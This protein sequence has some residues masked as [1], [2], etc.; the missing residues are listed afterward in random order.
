V[1]RKYFITVLLTLMQSNIFSQVPSVSSGSIVRYEN[2]KSK[3]ITPRN[4]DVWLPQDYDTA[5]KYAVLYMQDGQM[6]FDSAIT[7]DGQEW[8]VDETMTRLMDENK[9]K[10]CIV[11]GIWNSGATRDADYIPQ[12]PIALLDD[13]T[14]K[15]ILKDVLQ[16]P[17]ADNYLLFITKELKPFID[18]TYSTLKDQ[19]NTFIAGSSKGGL[20]SLYAICEYPYVFGGA[21]CISIHWPGLMRQ[22]RQ[23][24][25]AMNKYLI[26][27]LP[28]SK[29]HKI[30]FDYG[31]ETLDAMYKP[32]QQMVDSTM[33]VK[34]YSEKNWMTKYF[35]GEDHSERAWQKRFNIPTEFLLP[36]KK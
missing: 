31:S 6:L 30:Y 24:P 35:P 28:S 17:R 23:F 11:V 25:E 15:E 29:N 4:I 34:G 18:S 12:K 13:S 10:P 8:M 32:W 3:Y 16:Q 27:K 21:A 7:W 26:E 22:N 2:F 1:I 19:A 36:I 33:R 20:I 9:I 5:K 14:R